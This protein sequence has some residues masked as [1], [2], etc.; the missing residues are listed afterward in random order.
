MVIR[1]SVP[2]ARGPVRNFPVQSGCYSERLRARANRPSAAGAAAPGSRG[3][4]SDADPLVSQ[5][6][7][8][9]LV[10]PPRDDALLPPASTLP[11]CVEVPRDEA[12][13]ADR[14]EHHQPL[15]DDERQPKLP[16]LEGGASSRVEQTVE[17]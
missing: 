1:F 10:N 14:R 3:R 17:L 13:G 11:T 16:D 9:P 7:A 5:G 12:D 6:A 8:R 2:A 15:Q 4:E